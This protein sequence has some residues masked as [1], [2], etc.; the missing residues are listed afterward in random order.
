[1]WTS[2]LSWGA[3]CFVI[4]IKDEFLNRGGLNPAVRETTL[5]AVA[6]IIVS[7]VGG[8]IG[9]IGPAQAHDKTDALVMKI[10]NVPCCLSAHTGCS[11]LTLCIAGADSKN[12]STI[13]HVRT[14]K[15][16]III[17]GVTDDGSK[18]KSMMSALTVIMKDFGAELTA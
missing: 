2:L 9:P 18:D 15:S 1:M 4:H 17:R 11:D 14:W 7:N 12:K 13:P 5:K 8:S 10:H 3:G 6:A 16:R